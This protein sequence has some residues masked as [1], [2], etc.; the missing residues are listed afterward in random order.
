[1]HSRLL[2]QD[3]PERSGL[4]IRKYLPE[5]SLFFDFFGNKFAACEFCCSFSITLGF[6]KINFEKKRQGNKLFA[7]QKRQ[8][9]LE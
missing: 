7:F 1:P 3:A 2:M 8:E 6:L 4:I 9:L 5:A